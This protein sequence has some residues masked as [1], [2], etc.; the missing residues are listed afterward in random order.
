MAA[1]IICKPRFNK[2]IKLNNSLRKPL[3]EPTRKVDGRNQRN[4]INFGGRLLP[5]RQRSVPDNGLL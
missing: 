4:K 2:S 1:A 5:E 3:T